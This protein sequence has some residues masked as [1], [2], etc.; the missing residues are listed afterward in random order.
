MGKSMDNS[1]PEIANNNRFITPNSRH[2]LSANP[3]CIITPRLTPMKQMDSNNNLHSINEFRLKMKPISSFNT[4]TSVNNKF[5]FPKCNSKMNVTFHADIKTVGNR[6][7]FNI[8]DRFRSRDD[9]HTYVNWARRSYD[10]SP[11]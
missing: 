1:L 2:Q 4:P 7:T 8:S 10:I 5:T 6:G 3:K 9:P 11:N